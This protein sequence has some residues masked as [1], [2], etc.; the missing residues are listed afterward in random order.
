MP[1]PIDAPADSSKDDAPASSTDST[2]TDAEKASEDA[3]KDKDVEFDGPFDEER[4]KRK[5]AA[6]KADASRRAAR[7]AELEAAQKARDEADMTE[8]QKAAARAEAA[9]T[10]LKEL[11]RLR[12]VDELATSL[13][14]PAVILTAADEDGIKAQAKA[15]KDA[16]AEATKPTAP[17]GNSPKPRLTPGAAGT[18]TDEVDVAA[19]AA[20]IKGH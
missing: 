9:E 6:M 8:A 17:G 4:A 1:E 20:R 10:E 2:K 3:A 15:F 7:L 5:I 16:V 18:D 14:V 11:R 12:K 19:M 13:G